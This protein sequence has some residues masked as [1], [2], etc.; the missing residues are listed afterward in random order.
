MN[1]SITEKV[2]CPAVDPKL[3]RSGRKSTD[4]L[5]SLGRSW[6]SKNFLTEKRISTT[7]LCNIQFFW[8]AETINVASEMI[9]EL[10]VSKFKRGLST[11]RT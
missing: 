3:P 7:T 4:E 2:M 5:F 10:F 9:G 11:Q 1:G 8:N 6:K